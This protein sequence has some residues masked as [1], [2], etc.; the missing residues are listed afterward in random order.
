MTTLSQQIS[1]PILQ[2][3]QGMVFTDPVLK[4]R[5]TYRSFTGQSF[6][7]SVGYN[8]NTYSD[9]KIKAVRMKHN[10]RSS[11]SVWG[12]VEIGDVLFVFLYEDMPTG[13]SQKDIIVD[14]DDNLFKIKD[15]TPLMEIVILITVEGG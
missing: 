10:K 5:V 9:K 14:N 2:F 12:K 4:E 15:I 6:D 8:V 11:E 7:R 3:L 1:V 13:L